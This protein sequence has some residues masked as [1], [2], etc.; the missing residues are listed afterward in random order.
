MYIWR[1]C[2]DNSTQLRYSQL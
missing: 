1:Q 2:A